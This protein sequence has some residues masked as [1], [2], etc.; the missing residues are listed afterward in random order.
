MYVSVCLL[1]LCVCLPVRLCALP[2]RAS[3]ESQGFD[4]LVVLPDLF[5]F[6][7]WLGGGG[8]DLESTAG[9]ASGL[10]K[11]PGVSCLVQAHPLRGLSGKRVSYVFSGTEGN[12]LS[13]AHTS[14]TLLT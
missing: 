7:T 3:F 9:R 11:A 12:L 6:M 1:F 8:A 10:R 5:A 2:A 4:A 13:I 14:L